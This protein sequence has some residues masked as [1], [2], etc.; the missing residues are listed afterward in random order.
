MCQGEEKQIKSEH[1]Q[2][3]RSVS[4]TLIIIVTEERARKI[5][6]CNTESLNVKAHRN[7][8]GNR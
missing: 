2:K 7:G 6:E 3:K 5:S 1:R 8:T 4:K